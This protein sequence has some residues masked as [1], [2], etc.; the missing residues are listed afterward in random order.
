MNCPYKWTHKRKICKGGFKD[1]KIGATRHKMLQND[2]NV[3]LCPC[4]NY[5]YKWPVKNKN[6]VICKRGMKFECNWNAP[7]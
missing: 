3:S 2:C 1:E 4:L 7:N 5:S 6:P